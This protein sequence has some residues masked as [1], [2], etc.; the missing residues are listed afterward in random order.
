MPHPAISVIVPAYNTAATIGECIDSILAQT[1]TD[2]EL[3]IADDGS[4]DNT[5]E[6]IS[7]Y[8]D[9]RMRLLRREHDFIATLNT[10]LYEAKGKYIARIDADDVMM[11]DRLRLQYEYMEAHPE[12]A[13]VGGG[14]EFF[15]DKRF[16][17]LG[18]TPGNEEKTK[19][20]KIGKA[21]AVT[22]YDL[23]DSCGIYNPTSMIR[24][25]VLR[26]Y[27]LKYEQGYI[28]AQDFRLWADMIK[29]DL[30]IHNIENVL[31]RY[32][33]SETQISSKHA[34]LQIKFTHEIQ[35]DLM[36]WIREREEEVKNDYEVVPVSGNKLSVCMSFLNEGEEVGNTVRS[37]RE[38][39][40][41]TVDIIV[42]NDASTDGYD[43]ESDL[44]GLNV[45]YFVNKRRI[46]AAAGKEKTVQISST[47]YFILIDAHMRFY[48]KDWATQLVAE[49][50]KN[51]NRLLC[52]QNLALSKKDGKLSKPVEMGVY[53]AYLRFDIG[54]NIPN[55]KWN[56]H[57]HVP[58]LSKGQ[59]PA[60]LGATYSTSKK[61]WNRLCGYQ[62]LI[63]YGDEEAYISIKAWMEGGGCYF[64]PNIKI[65]HIY[66]EESP[67]IVHRN[68]MTYNILLIGKIFMPSL[69]SC[70]SESVAIG[71]SHNAE[72]L[73]RLFS[74][75]EEEI[76]ALCEKYTKSF[77]YDFSRILK[78]NSIL[79]HHEEKEVKLSAKRLPQIMDMLLKWL[80]RKERLY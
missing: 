66:R 54:R 55:I 30:I 12:V 48:Q 34:A 24:S 52:C 5:C 41:D 4:T 72:A 67:Y 58:T 6:I 73:A 2:F 71:Y 47:P 31:T 27:G 61:Y 62:G 15:S 37:I 77:K 29:H 70:F 60:V 64:L 76:R 65:G 59:I 69:L 43:Y 8:K 45:H 21:H 40:G 22:A 78:I 49:L 32:R 14:M 63:H 53:G 42:V 10:L 44:K 80:W 20:E 36:Q 9:P 35:Q 51:S 68:M 1:F 33:T 57:E 16:A 19:E 18:K 28:C 56:D 46:G 26:R 79:L 25:G 74:S 23:L 50:E 39:A 75:R 3:I 38:T 7:R 11:P 13:V 17:F